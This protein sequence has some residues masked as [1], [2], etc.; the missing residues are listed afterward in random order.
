M[1]ADG[2]AAAASGASGRA[3]VSGAAAC[4]HCGSPLPEAE[5][6]AQPAGPIADGFCCAGCAA[7]YDLVRGLGL[8]SYYQRRTLDPH[9]RLLIPDEEGS[10]CDLGAYV[11][12]SND[13]DCSLSLMVEGLHCAACVWL[14]ESVLSRQPEVTS[15]RVN[16]TTRR[17]ALRWHGGRARAE[18]LI[19]AVGRLGYRLVPFD[20]GARQGSADRAERALLRAMAVA[21]FAAGNVMLLSVAV[22][23]GHAQGMGPAT[24]GLLHWISA[25]IAL[26]AIAYAG[27]S[28]F[29]SA[30]AVLRH[31]RTNMDVPISIGVI[32]TAA[33]S[34]HETMRGAEHAYFDSAI[35]LLFF[36]LIGRYLD[37][38]ARGVALATVENV[39]ALGAAAVT[40]EE[41]DGRR[42]RL[43]PAAVEVGMRVAVAAGERIAV[44]GQ[45]VSGQSSIDTSLIDGEATPKP[46]GPG[47]SVFAGCLNIENP[48]VIE[49]AAVGERTLLAEIARLVEAAEN[50]KSRFVALADKVSR[51]YAPVVHSAALLTFLGW[52]LLLDVP[53]QQA[54]LNA[55]AVLIITC[56]CALALA[57][58]VVQVVAIS[59]L[60]R[61]GVLVK[62]GTALER[63]AA[64]EIIAFDKT[65]T[66]T[67]GRPELADAGTVETSVLVQAAA[68]AARS[69]HPLARALVRAAETRGLLPPMLA[70]VREVAGQG[71]EVATAAGPIRLGSRG[72]CGVAGTESG[73]AGSEIWFARPDEA[74]VRFVFA[75]QVR[76]DAAEVVQDLAADGYQLALL[77]GDRAP[78]VVAVAATVGIADFRPQLSPLDKVA[79]LRALA[80]QG[81]RVLMV[82]DG[83]NDAPALA[84]AH[85]SLSPATAADIAQTAADV[86][87]QGDRLEPVRESLIVAKRARVLVIENLAL[88][89]GYNTLTVPLAVAGMVTPLIAAIAMS[90][91]SLIVILNALRLHSGR[92]RKPSRP[93]RK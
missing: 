46:A 7:A 73:Q 71:L 3:P 45:I 31:G 54:L 2:A 48:L 68:L 88:S 12:E 29:R 86:V 50:Q 72:F 83:L 30:I 66:L 58:P 55:I 70:D 82:G 87:F 81:R 9:Q 60:L 10:A 80:D 52:L 18:E 16:M 23:A 35:G 20:A 49:A 24:R 63:L 57:I 59:R 32:L 62:S 38:R 33:M 21:G 15:A 75:D 61:R 27:R 53:W 93:L 78:A 34:L 28:F 69:R 44:D 79:H 17:L 37:R 91:S 92:A 22:W 67:V 6:A 89:L 4:R 77:S 26:P 40:V 39:L 5:G 76:P 42:R 11:R 8:E 65:G 51:A 19:G 85:V 64:A 84:V 36:L 43:P 41:A 25:L 47:G 74:P 56:P 90:L 1:T 14:I 13:G